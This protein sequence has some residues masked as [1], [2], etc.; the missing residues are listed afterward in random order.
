[1]TPQCY[2]DYNK[3]HLGFNTSFSRPS[4]SWEQSRDD[5]S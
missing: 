2:T 1:M 3:T 4:D 5:E